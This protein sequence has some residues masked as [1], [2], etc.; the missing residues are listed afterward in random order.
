MEVV[1]IPAIAAH[2]A[3]TRVELAGSRSRGEHAELSDC[4][5]R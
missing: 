5:G 1:A 2:P 4:A 3:V